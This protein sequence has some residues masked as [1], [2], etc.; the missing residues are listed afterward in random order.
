MDQGFFNN[1]F[2][3][4]IKLNNI[5]LKNFCL[6]KS[7]INSRLVSTISKIVSIYFQ[8]KALNSLVSNIFEFFKD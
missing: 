7:M 6:C 5:F 2:F 1:K 4:G 3:D 8:S